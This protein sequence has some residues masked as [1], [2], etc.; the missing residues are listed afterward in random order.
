MVME[1]S[2]CY[3]DGDSVGVLPESHNTPENGTII[4]NVLISP[5]NTNLHEP[6]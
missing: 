1:C 3:G 6:A 2:S 4:V 5:E